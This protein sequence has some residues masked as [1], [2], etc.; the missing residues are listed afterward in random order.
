MFDA[1]KA[2]LDDNLVV[3]ILAQP[4]PIR[5]WVLWLMLINTASLLFVRGFPGRAVLLIWIGNALTMS[6]MFAVVGYVR[7]LG[8]S[9]VLWWTPMFVLL[10]RRRA[11]LSRTVLGDAQFVWLLLLCVSDGVSLAIDYVDVIRYIAGD[12]LAH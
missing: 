2:A 1:L 10:W 5:D 4:A 3:H 11:E 7:L 12:R 8:L 9:H 6:A